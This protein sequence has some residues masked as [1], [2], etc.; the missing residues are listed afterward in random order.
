MVEADKIRRAIHLLYPLALVYYWLPADGFI[1]IGKAYLVVAVLVVFF[2]N[3]AVRLA[4]KYRMP[5]I[6]ENERSR[7][8]AYA[9]GSLGIGIAIVFFPLP[10]AAVVVCGMAWVDPLCHSTRETGGY[11]VVPIIV[12]FVLAAMF[13]LFANYDPMMSMFYGAVGAAAAIVAEAPKIKWIDD[14]FVMTIVPLIVLGA[15][16]ASLGGLLA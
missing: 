12:Y 5:L 16:T 10:V 14:D 2:V 13:F 1:G 6:R 3:E 7:I 4:T 11:P 8:G 15:L 9:L